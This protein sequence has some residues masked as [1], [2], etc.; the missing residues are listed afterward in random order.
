MIY[1][2]FAVYCLVAM[3]LAFAAL[4]DYVSAY[5]GGGWH[6]GKNQFVLGFTGWVALVFLVVFTLV[7]GGF[8]W[9]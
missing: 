1:W 9:W 2:D 7:W 6:G 4:Y 8:F 3:V 5:G